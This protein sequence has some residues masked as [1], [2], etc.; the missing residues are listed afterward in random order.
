MHNSN[1]PKENV[2]QTTE[3]SAHSSNQNDHTDR[4]EQADEKKENDPPQERS[5]PNYQTIY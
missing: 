5:N 1:N 2:E 3:L 4:F